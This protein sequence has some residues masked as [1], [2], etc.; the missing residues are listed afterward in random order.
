MNSSP[1]ESNP[2]TPNPSDI[3]ERQALALERLAVVSD[4]EYKP[5]K[6]FIQHL[7]GFVVAGFGIAAGGYEFVQFIIESH[8]RRLLVSNWVTAAKEMFEAEGSA[9][10]ASQLLEQ[11]REVAP[12]DANVIRY[13]AYVD[14]MSVVERLLNLDRPFNN[15]DVE[16]YGK[17]MGQAVMLERVDSSSPEWAILRGQLALAVDEPLRAQM[18]LDQA[19]EIDPAHSFARLRLALVKLSIAKSRESSAER[20]ALVN[21]ARSMIDKIIEAEP[22]NKWAHLWRG[23]VS[24]EWDAE[25]Q[26]AVESF[27]SAL[28]IDPRFVNAW[29]SLGSAQEMLQD[30]SAAE[31]AFSRALQLRPN[32][33]SA[34]TGLAYVYGYQDRYEVGLA[35]ARRATVEAP[36]SFQAWITRGLLARELWRVTPASDPSVNDLLK[37]AVDSYTAALDL[38][39]RSSDVFIERSKLYRQTGR[40]RESG[41]DARSAINFSPTDPVAWNV[42]AKYYQAA[43]FLNDAVE[44]F[45]KVLQLDPAMDT[46]LLDRGQIYA[47]LN[48]HESA[49]ADFDA[50]LKVATDDFSPEILCA[51]AAVYRTTQRLDLALADFVQART[52]K[53]DYLDAWLGESQTLDTLGRSAD[54]LVA[55]NEALKLAPDNTRLVEW[56]SDLK[57]R[58]P[59]SH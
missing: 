14:G 46:A 9:A 30:F 41:S 40:L 18:F 3:H 48:E 51:R 49:I 31:K 47:T 19:I 58:N 4:P 29:Q 42:L 16:A 1:P 12:Q 52:V 39:P 10:E 5:R 55:A 2:T 13:A 36:Q 25:P 23:T 17:A 59:P 22:S 54:A 33:V 15:S 50:A 34:Y 37:E 38:N 43:G 32:L 24:L 28:A 21:E 7:A 44:T 35:F 11:A 53:P 6:K 20:N 27:Q 8:E 57:Q 56:V 26:R 45:T